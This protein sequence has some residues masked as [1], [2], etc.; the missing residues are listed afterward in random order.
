MSWRLFFPHTGCHLYLPRPVENGTL[1]FNGT[2]GYLHIKE[3]TAGGS[4]TLNLEMVKSAMY[5]EGE[6]SV[7]NYVARYTDNYNSGAGTLKVYGTFTPAAQRSGNDAFFGQEMQDGAKIDLS[8]KTTAFGVVGLGFT[9]EDSN[10]T[11]TFENG[12]TVGVLLGTRKLAN[13]ARIIDWSAAVPENRA[14]LK[15]YGQFAD[16]KRINLMVRDDGVYAPKKGLM[17][18]VR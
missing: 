16:G 7:S 10:R 17:L 9:N 13:G 8:S 18:V 14:D 5:I 15:F 6:F 12:A 1:L 4:Q 3:A 11:M 2:G